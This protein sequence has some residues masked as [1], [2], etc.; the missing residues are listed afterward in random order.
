MT[1]SQMV[2]RRFDLHVDREAKGLDDVRDWLLKLVAR[3]S[4][5]SDGKRDPQIKP[6]RSQSLLEVRLEGSSPALSSVMAQVA[7]EPGVRIHH[8]RISVTETEAAPHR[9]Q[10][11]LEPREREY[12]D[13]RT[14]LRI[15]MEPRSK[16]T[17]PPSAPVTVAVVDSGIMVDHPDLKDRLWSGIVAG[18][19]ANGARCIG[20]TQTGDVTDQDGHGTR[21]AGTI[22]SV[23]QDAPGIRLMAVKFFDPDALPGP[24]N[25]ADAINFAVERKADIINLSWDLG[26]GSVAVE[27]AIQNACDAG[28]LVVI[29]AGNSGTD[30]DRFPTIPACYRKERPSRII[31]VLATDRYDM[32]ASFSNYGVNT[33]DLGA[34][35][36][37]CVTTRAALATTSRVGGRQYRPYNGTSPAAALVAGAAAQLKSR[38]PKLT[39][40]QL[41][42][43]LCLSV[44]RV[45]GL[46]CRTG[47]RLNLR[48]ALE[49]C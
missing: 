13:S 32:K 1:M 28:A 7:Q 3:E 2:V 26:I 21:L 10:A 19:Q 36:V 27:Q 46:K 17:L 22:L 35:G 4:K 48:R 40:D 16:L 49:R 8:D 25:G 12:P 24:G 41:K 15:G 47:G 33:V 20:G 45:P 5:K 23:A 18:H 6:V 31:T 43:C 34:P 14:L 11:K 37:D 44:D 42:E 29:A 30:N 39:A 9:A 38:N